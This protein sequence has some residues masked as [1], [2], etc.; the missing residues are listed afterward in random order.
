MLSEAA[1]WDADG[2]MST[3]DFAGFRVGFPAF[4]PITNNS[5]G[6]PHAA[7]QLYYL[8]EHIL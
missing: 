2:V 1:F 5:D 4:C 8:R 7:L 3:V 6:M